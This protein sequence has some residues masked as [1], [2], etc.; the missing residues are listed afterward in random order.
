MTLDERTDIAGAQPVYWQILGEN[1]VLIKVVCHG[2][3]HLQWPMVQDQELVGFQ[4]QQ[5]IRSPVV[6]R[7]L[8]FESIGRVHFNDC[9]DLAAYQ[10]LVRQVLSQ[11]HHV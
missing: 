3:R 4:R 10:F 11:R 7:K 6:I 1:D 9:S 5:R 2:S 8:D